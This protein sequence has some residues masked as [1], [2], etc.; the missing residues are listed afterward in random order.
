MAAPMN[1]LPVARGATIGVLLLAAAT[2]QQPRLQVTPFAV[3]RTQAAATLNWSAHGPGGDL[4]VLLADT[5]PGP[6]SL[7]GSTFD[8]GFSPLAF[9]LD[10]GVLAP[11]GSYGFAQF[12]PSAL[13]AG[14]LFFQFASW[15]PTTWFPPLRPSTNTSMVV[16]DHT[17]AIAVEFDWGSVPALTGVFDRTVTHRLQASPPTVRTVQPL[18]SPALPFLAQSSLQP[19]HPEGSRFQTVLRASD[20][21]ASGVPEQLTAVRWRP[22][23]G[24]VAPEWYAQFELRAA[25]TD[26]VPD[27][28]VDPWSALPVAPN[29][30]LQTTFAANPAPGAPPT[31]LYAGPYPVSPQALRPNGYLPYP[32]P[33]QSF[34]WDGQRSL[35]L[36]TQCPPM[37]GGGLPQNFHLLYLLVLSS[38]QPF[39]TVAAVAGT[40]GQPSPLPPA[41]TPTGVGGSYVLDLELEFQRVTSQ[42]TGPWILTG[43]TFPDYQA[44]QI[45]AGVPPGTSLVVEFRGATNPQ[46]TGATAWSTNPDDADGNAFLQYRVTMTADPVTGAVPWIDALVVPFL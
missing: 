14:P 12:V 45:A 44:P 18:P 7:F 25:H 23:F 4:F 13:P 29:S 24:I 2:A 27:Y 43:P 8:L 15:N 19:L 42:A 36:E 1:P 40:Q 10:A 17:F 20:L 21:G 6:S 32:S 11:L 33:Q 28:R 41:T 34:T 26:V 22:M 39:G 3:S 16:H 35:L 38:P 46:G 9:V 5:S 30:G 31:L 37:Q